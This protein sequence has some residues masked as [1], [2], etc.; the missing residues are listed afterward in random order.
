[1]TFWNRAV[2]SLVIES[3]S[4]RRLLISSRLRYHRN[5]FRIAS[6]ILLKP[7][8]LVFRLVNIPNISSCEIRAVYRKIPQSN[9]I[10]RQCLP[11]V[12]DR[13]SKVRS[14]VRW[15]KAGSLNTAVVPSRSVSSFVCADNITKSLPTETDELS[16]SGRKINA[17]ER[18]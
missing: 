5:A 16:D 17:G 6:H 12:T 11:S 3:R 14:Q 9:F 13:T 1:M 18:I 7:L 2:I 10:L 15:F 8:P 4:V